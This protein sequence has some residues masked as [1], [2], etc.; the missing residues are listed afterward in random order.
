MPVCGGGDES[1]AG[2]LVGLPVWAFH[3]ALDPVVP[4]ERSRQMIAAI[5][6]AGGTPRYTEY[7]DV[8]HHSWTPA[9]GDSQGVIPW[10][11]QQARPS[12]IR[13]ATPV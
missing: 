10:L 6:A 3:G 1:L 11:F 8:E 9:Y 7:A 2:R 12:S 5:R 4:V 13:P